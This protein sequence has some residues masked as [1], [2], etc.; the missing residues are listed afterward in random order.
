MPVLK[1]RLVQGRPFLLLFA[2]VFLRFLY[3]GFRYFPQIDDYIQYSSYNLLPTANWLKDTITRSLNTTRPLASFLDRTLWSSFLGAMI[4]PV[5]AISAMYAAAALMLRSVFSRRFSVSWLFLILIAI[6]PVTFEGTYWMS[7]ST[8]IVTGL[9]FV[10][11]SLKF[12]EKWTFSGHWYYLAL[13]L[14]AQLIGAN[15]YE[16]VLVFSVMA[17]LILA[18]LYVKEQKRAYAGLACVPIAAAAYWLTKA[19]SRSALLQTRSETIFPTDSGYFTSFMP[20]VLQQLKSVF[21]GGSFYTLVKGFVR[22]AVILVTSPNFI[23][24]IALLAAITLLFLFLRKPSEKDDENLPGK[25]KFVLQIIIGAILAAAPLAPFF[26]LTQTF[27]SLRAIITSLPGIALIADAVFGLCLSKAA[28][29]RTISA[30]IVSAF[31]LVFCI[32]SV[33]ELHD[34]MLTTKYDSE[35]VTLLAETVAANDHTS[36]E[37]V[38]ILNVSQ[39]YLTEQNYFYHEHIHGVTE[40]SWAL[41][42]ALNYF[43]NK[44]RLRVVPLPTGIMYEPWA[45]ATSQLSNFRVLYMLL[46]N[47]DNEFVMVPVTAVSDANGRT[48]LIHRD[49]QQLLAISWE[50]DNYGYLELAE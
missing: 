12:F 49:T 28:A 46:K 4:V 19:L 25:R 6:L 20:E 8:R 5:A 9:F 2:L 31:A 29:R 23:Y 15:L 40:S 44:Y 50:E 45:K 33:S 42:G 34:Y 32:A 21:L 41:T 47:E 18:V 24:I 26:I 1:R 38:G 43:G 37:S 13:F 30:A 36:G 27:I 48:K 39:I 22:G 7:A 3:Y 17:T 16:Q 11:M 14:T 35:I 10:A